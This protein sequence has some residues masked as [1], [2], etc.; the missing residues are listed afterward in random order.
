[1]LDNILAL[2]E[3]E[4]HL[5]RFVSEDFVWRI[6]EEDFSVYAHLESLP[7]SRSDL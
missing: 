1:M 6:L 4:E 7:M 2:R 5:G 3:I